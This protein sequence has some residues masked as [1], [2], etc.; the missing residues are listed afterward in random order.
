MTIRKLN[1]RETFGEALLE[2]GKKD[3]NIMAV[4]CDSGAGSGMNPFKEALP[5]QYL[6][7]GIN[8]QNAIGVCAG[9]AEAGFIPVVSAIAPFIS[10]RAFEQVRND[11]AYAK[12]NVK[13]IGSSSGLSHCALGSTHQAIE[14]LALMRVL[15]NMV[16]LNPGDG[17]EVEIAL[18]EAINHVGPVYLR[19]PRHPMAE[20]LEVSQRSIKLGKGE[21][22]L[23][24][25]DEIV[26]AVTGT[27]STDGLL[28]GKALQEKGYGVKV[29]NFTTVKPL[30]VK[31]LKDAY[32]K[33]NYLFTLEEHSEIGGFGGAVLEALGTI[34][35]NAPIHRFA[36][37]D[38][39]VNTGPYRELLGAYGLTYEEVTKNILKEIK[40]K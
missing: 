18:R 4:S 36:I 29:L 33:A 13:I 2:L 1:P 27:L 31:L 9:L 28:A 19:M 37:A 10:M 17:Y 21:V 35:H 5:D 12:M 3:K 26:I 25:G 39:S 11:V 40:N 34:K 16:V 22:L 14:D 23:D 7:V 30:D 6:E 32:Q 15:P 8:E 24:A 20:P 38:G